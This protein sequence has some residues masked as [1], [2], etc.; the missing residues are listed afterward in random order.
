MAAPD[1]DFWT[2]SMPFKATDATLE[3]VVSQTGLRMLIHEHLSKFI[4]SYKEDRRAPDRA[5]D[6]VR[7]HQQITAQLG[8]RYLTMTRVVTS[9]VPT[10]KS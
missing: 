7:Y 6:S 9:R 4:L 10:K 1:A 5:L 2:L 8:L 3:K